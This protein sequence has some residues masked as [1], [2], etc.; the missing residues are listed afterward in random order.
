MPEEYLPD[1]PPTTH[2]MYAPDRVYPNE[3]APPD[4]YETFDETTAF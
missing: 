2:W 3:P 4:S 1:R